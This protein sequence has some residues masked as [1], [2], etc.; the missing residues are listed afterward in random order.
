MSAM[1]DQAI[2]STEQLRAFYEPPNAIVLD[3]VITT[4][5]KHT[6]AFVQASTFLAVVRLALPGSLIPRPSRSIS[7]PTAGLIADFRSRRTVSIP[8]AFFSSSPESRSPC[9]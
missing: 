2:S 1:M 6:S 3:K 7:R 4:F 5:D 8:S 9:G